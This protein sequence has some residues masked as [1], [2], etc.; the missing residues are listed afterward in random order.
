MSNS[1]QTLKAARKPMVAPT[2]L[3]LKS[4]AIGLGC[5]S[6]LRALPT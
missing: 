3:R 5:S 2:I 6:P 1:N 4:R